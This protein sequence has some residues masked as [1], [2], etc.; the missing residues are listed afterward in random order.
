MSSPAVVS[1]SAPASAS[2]GKSSKVSV[3]RD[4]DSPLE[5]DGFEPSV[6]PTGCAGL[7]RERVRCRKG[8]AWRLRF[9]PSRR[10]RISAAACIPVRSVLRIVV[11][12]VEGE[13]YTKLVQHK[14]GARAL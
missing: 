4:V 7:F 8:R 3:G 13:I 14:G 11:V 12:A 6:P 9:M 10:S 2:N 1:S 5:E